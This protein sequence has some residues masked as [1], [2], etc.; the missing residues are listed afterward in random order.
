MAVFFGDVVPS[1]RKECDCR[2]SLESCLH[3]GDG[4][5]YANKQCPYK[6]IEKESGNK[7]TL[8]K[9]SASSLSVPFYVVI[10][11]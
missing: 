8:M 10:N 6:R 5:S 7:T 2:C 11:I 3:K 9:Y 1:L 4:E